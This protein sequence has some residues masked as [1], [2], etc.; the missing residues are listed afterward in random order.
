MSK[1]NL[2]HTRSEVILKFYNQKAFMPDFVSS[3]VEVFLQE[4]IHTQ[5][6]LN[7]IFHLLKKYDLATKEERDQRNLKLI[8]YSK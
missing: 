2:N 1:C 6:E 7:E 8:S 4:D 3:K 5:E